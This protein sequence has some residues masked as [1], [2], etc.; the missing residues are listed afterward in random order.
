MVKK[1]K[2]GLQLVDAVFTE[3]PF[4]EHTGDD[5]TTYIEVEPDTEYFVKVDI[6]AGY[7]SIGYRI[8]VDEEDLGYW[9]RNNK[10][11]ELSG[12]WSFING[13]STMRALKFRGL[14][15]QVKSKT[16]ISSPNDSDGSWVGEIVITF[17]ERIKLEG[18]HDVPDVTSKW[19]GS[20]KS[21]SEIKGSK[22]K[23][24]KSGRGTIAKSKTA[25][26]K[27]ENW[28]VGKKLETITVKYCTTVELIHAGVLPKPPHWNWARFNFPDAGLN[29]NATALEPEIL[30]FAAATTQ[31]GKVI[32]ETKNVEMFNLIASDD[33]SSD[34]DSSNSSL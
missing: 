10:G 28:K 20:R 7:N 18:Y 14:H 33:E 31:D 8:Q 16:T 25:A 12:L 4:K 17:Y 30:T 1:G 3:V 19:K 22:K 13:Q 5:G 32:G 15:N 2:F 9:G 24:V 11:Q 23:L 26:Q 27:V 6:D 29:N 34:S 21:L